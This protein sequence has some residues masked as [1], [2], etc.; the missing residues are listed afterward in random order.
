[1]SNSTSISDPKKI[2]ER[3][4]CIILLLYLGSLWILFQT[5]SFQ[6]KGGVVSLSFILATPFAAGALSVSIG[7]WTG[8]NRWLLHSII[9]P[10]T[11]LFIGVIVTYVFEFE[12]LLCVAMATPVMLMGAV[13]GG[14]IAHCLLPKNKDRSKLYITFS[15]FTPILL[16]YVENFFHWPHEIKQIENTII[17]NASPQV[18]WKKISSVSAI[19]PSTIPNKW[20]YSLGFP[21]PIS[22]TLSHEGIGG[23]R[24]AT[25]ERNVSFFET[26]TEWNYPKKLSFTIKADPDFIPHT[27]FD[28]HIIVGGRFYDVLDG[29]YVIESLTDTQCILR[30]TSTHR[31]STRFNAYAGWWSEK[32]M[33]Q[34]QSSILEVIRKRA[35]YENINASLIFSRLNAMSSI[36]LEKQNND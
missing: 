20:I 35:E 30:L 4:S 36:A 12:S 7:R 8:S 18:I 33:D 16:I 29:T 32:I 21:K 15:V 25:F 6:G 31:L 9:L 34:I 26:I 17:I 10:S 11:A 14:S 13:I 22:A 28:R 2:G 3:V 19:E 27:A 23:I 1:M 24:I 5:D